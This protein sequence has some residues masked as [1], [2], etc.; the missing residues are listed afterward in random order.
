MEI[1]S[2]FNRPAD[3]KVVDRDPN[4]L[5]WFEARKV[6]IE[7]ADGVEFLLESLASGESAAWVLPCLPLHLAYHWLLAR[8]GS[9]ARAIPVPPEL[10]DHLPNRLPAESNGF[11]TSLADF[12]CPVDC[13]EPARI[14]P[15]TGRPRPGTLFADLAAGNWPGFTMLVVRGRQLAPGLGGLRPDD[16]FSLERKS[17]EAGGRVL[18]ATACRCHGVVHG[19]TSR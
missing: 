9:K 2:R 10:G 7:P 18:V 14:C 13:P 8:L 19:L 4:A 11:Y 1:L 17:I 15:A 12:L 16:L 6:Q 3:L 5:T